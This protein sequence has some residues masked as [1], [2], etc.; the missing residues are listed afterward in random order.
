MAYLDMHV[1]LW[2][3]RLSLLV[4]WEQHTKRNLLMRGRREVGLTETA[5]KSPSNTAKL[6][7]GDN[8]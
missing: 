7:R 4:E 5:P 3:Q 8:C 6:G 1:L 2:V